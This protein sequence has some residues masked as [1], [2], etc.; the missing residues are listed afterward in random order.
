MRATPRAIRFWAKVDKC[1]GPIV[2]RRLGRCWI[3]TARCNAAGYGQLELNGHV[4]LAHRIAW[5][6]SGARIPGSLFVLHKCDTP[7]CVRRSHLFLGDQF[8]NMRDSVCKGRKN[9]PRGAAHWMR[10]RKPCDVHC[11]LFRGLKLT[12]CDARLIRKLAGTMPVAELAERFNVQGTQIW[13]VVNNRQ[14]KE[15]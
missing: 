3:W 9:M 2:S 7:S 15:I 11:G 12:L 13:R 6:L 5:I 1:N 10:N 8:D 14:W 4:V